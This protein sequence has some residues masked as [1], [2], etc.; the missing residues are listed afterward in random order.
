MLEFAEGATAIA[1]GAVGFV[2]ACSWSVCHYEGSD[3]LSVQFDWQ[4]E[5]FES[6]RPLFSNKPLIVCANKTDIVTLDELAPEK[7][8]CG[9]I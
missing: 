2:E 4:V 9:V 3:G 5:L 6:I 7:K 8:V 1:E